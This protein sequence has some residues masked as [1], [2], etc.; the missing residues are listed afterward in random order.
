MN[1]ISSGFKE[2]KHGI[3]SYYLMKGMEGFA[4]E[5]NDRSIT[6]GELLNY[7]TKNVSNKAI[8][9]GRSQKPSLAGSMDQNLLRY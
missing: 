3:F 8:E 2:A 7:M 1:Q 4:D 9:L 5:N 6:N